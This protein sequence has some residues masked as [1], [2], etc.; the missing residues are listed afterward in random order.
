MLNVGRLTL[1]SVN[2][3]LVSLYFFPVWGREAIRALISPL[4]G[5]EHRVHAAATIYVGELFNFGFSGLALTS[6][7]LAGIKLVIAAAF[8][9]YAIEFVRS[10]VMGRDTDPETTDVALILAAVGIAVFVLPAALGDPILLRLAATQTLLVAGA[11][12]IVAVERRIA[13][14][15]ET[16][17][18]GDGAFADVSPVAAVAAPDA[19]LHRA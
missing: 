13:A 17:R 11:I 18:I 12:M 15:V 4:H 2:L 19:R 10:W 1:G 3:A 5:L 6:G 16:S 7:V 14:A 9:M 8:A